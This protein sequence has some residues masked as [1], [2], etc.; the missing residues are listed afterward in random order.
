MPQALIAKL[1]EANKE[2]TLKHLFG[3]A[4]IFASLSISAFA[5]K[6]SQTVRLSTPVKVGTTQLPAGEYKVSWTGTGPSVQ[7]TIAQSGKTSVTVPAKAVESKNGHTAV[8]T[9]SA[10]GDNVLQSIE[11]DNLTLQ[12][13]GEGANASGQ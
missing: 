3:Y 6:N 8:L 13:A 4:I 2:I 9:S 7:V 12:I 11:L 5:A 1:N 10:S